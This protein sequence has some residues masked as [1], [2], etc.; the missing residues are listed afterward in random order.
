VS[1]QYHLGRKPLYRNRRPQVFRRR[2][3]AV[4][5]Q[6]KH[7]QAPAVTVTTSATV[8][9]PSMIWTGVSS[10]SA[11]EGT[12]SSLVLATFTD[13]GGAEALK[14]YFAIIAW[15]DGKTSSGVI[16]VNN[17][18]FTVSG[19]HQYAEQGPY[20]IQVT[21]GHDSTSSMIVTDTMT[22]SEASLIASGQSIAVAEGAATG[23]VT[24][25]TFVD[26]GGPES[27][28]DY[29]ATIKWGDNSTDSAGVIQP[30]GD[31]KT[32]RVVGSHTYA[33]EG[34]YSITATINHETAP[35]VTVTSSANVSDP[36]VIGTPALTNLAQGVNYT[37]ISV[38]TFAD[39]GVNA[40][41]APE[42]LA[43]Y[44]A[45][46]N[47]GDNTS[48]TGTISVSSGT[49]TVTGSHT[50]STFG[51]LTVVVTLM[52]DN[53]PPTTV[54][55]TVVVGPSVIV[56]N[57]TLSGALTVSG[58]SFINVKGDIVVDSNST[59]ALTISGTSQITATQILVVGGVSKTG[60]PI[61]TPAPTT[62]VASV[63]DPFAA[64]ATPSAAGL[65]NQGSAS[66]STGT[67]TLNPGI[68][69][70]ISV[71][72]GAGV[73]LNP[74]TY[75]IKGGGIDGERRGE[76]ERLRS[77]HLQCRQQ[78]PERRGNLRRHH[79]QQQRRRDI[80]GPHVGTL[81]Q[82]FDLPIPRQ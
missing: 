23:L 35:T 61:L 34:T 24:V 22:V 44:G 40:G 3:L 8:A 66:F 20:S 11:V 6:I 27:V 71:T 59:S 31:G 37:N 55:E 17:G 10:L 82:H 57:P 14:D 58:S 74:G 54:T 48:S 63:P 32:F 51:S 13:P 69:T 68:Y 46:I 43:D 39:P 16:A 12:T 30:T 65:V 7:D 79:H 29:S 70:Q 62:H 47:W 9:D 60:S 78:F 33:E 56:L 75:V 42:A 76:F 15:G 25:A 67:H 52:H 64:L 38:A 50:Y 45:S 1:G 2:K 53:S 19:S 72:N 28:S 4:S 21:I 80:V 5:V 18:A 26:L 41:T 81:C 73:I 49:F 77:L 36:A